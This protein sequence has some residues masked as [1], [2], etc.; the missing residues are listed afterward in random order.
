MHDKHVLGHQRKWASQR[1]FPFGASFTF[2]CKCCT[3]PGLIKSEDPGS[4][5]ICI[6]DIAKYHFTLIPIDK[7][8]DIIFLLNTYTRQLIIKYYHSQC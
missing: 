3:E 1:L 6:I 4:G 5:S 2:A 8:K 7:G